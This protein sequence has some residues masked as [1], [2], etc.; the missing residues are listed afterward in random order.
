MQ[1]LSQLGP[2][3][4]F[5]DGLA[6]VALYFDFSHFFLSGNP[7]ADVWHRVTDLTPH[8]RFLRPKLWPL[9][10]IECGNTVLGH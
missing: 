3:A 2:T 5:L 9:D 6:W 10:R 7:V 1:C 4:S 8:N